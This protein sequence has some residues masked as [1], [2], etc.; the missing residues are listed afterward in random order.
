MSTTTAAS[1][2]IVAGALSASK[3]VYTTAPVAVAE[4]AMILAWSRRS[5]STNPVP[6]PERY[7]GMIVT[8]A[9]LA[10]PAD[11]CNS[12]FARLLQATVHKLAEDVFVN[13]CKQDGNLQRAEYDGAAITVDSALAYWAE[14]RAREQ[15]TAANIVEWLNQSAT[16][17]ALPS[18][19]V[20]KVWLANVPKIAAPSYK[21]AFDAESAAKIAARIVEADHEHAICAFI[22]Q[23]CANIMSAE[24]PTADAF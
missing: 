12:K 8:K 17:K 3:Q 5:T 19:Q 11:A 13:W 6:A 22:L 1:P 10:V 18:E 14:E 9:A 15:I 20:R 23:R 16:F 4:D 21:Q 2:A 7:R 24:R